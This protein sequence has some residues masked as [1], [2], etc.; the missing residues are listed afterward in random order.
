MGVYIKNG[1]SVTTIKIA[2]IMKVSLKTIFS[3]PLLVKEEELDEGLPKPVPL[4]WIKI[5]LISVIADIICAIW[6]TLFIYKSL[7]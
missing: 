6:N 3:I 2:A 5:R 7:L 4:D 1:K